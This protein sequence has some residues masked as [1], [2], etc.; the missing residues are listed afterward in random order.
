MRILTRYILWE[1]TGVFLVTLATMTAFL[2]VALI[3]KEAVENGLGL[4]P[5]VR[6]LPY[7]LPQAMQFTVPAALLM[8]ATSVFGRVSAFNEVVA[9]KALGISP[10][11]LV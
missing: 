10:M 5:I 6:M 3:G 11:V 2:F 9:I 8:A 4:T 1:V 7:M